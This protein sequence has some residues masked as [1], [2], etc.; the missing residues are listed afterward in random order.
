MLAKLDDS[1]RKRRG[2][3]MNNSEKNEI[4]EELHIVVVFVTVFDVV[5]Q[6]RQV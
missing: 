4:G 3:L 1:G 6:N 5:E 2:R